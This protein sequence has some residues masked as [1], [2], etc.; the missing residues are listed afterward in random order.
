MKKSGL[1]KKIRV[2]LA[3]R[4]PRRRDLMTRILP[5]ASFTCVKSRIQEKAR[6]E[7]PPRTFAIRMAEAKASEVAGRIRILP[8]QTAIIMAADTV[9]DLDGE[10]IGQPRNPAHARSILVRLSGRRHRVVT[11]LAF[12]RRPGKRRIRR[13]VTSS[14]WMKKLDPKTIDEYMKARESMD[15]AGAYGIQGMGKRLVRKYR[16][17]YTNIVGFP[18][19]EIRKILRTL[20]RDE[21]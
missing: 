17:S 10:I 4:S 9:I 8:G 11:G 12:I 14:V 13:S 7:E 16:G 1:R 6:P 20:T 3:S 5:R 18:V 21:D 19:P 2:I 15:K